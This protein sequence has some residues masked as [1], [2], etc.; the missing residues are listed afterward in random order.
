LYLDEG[1]LLAAVS[2]EESLQKLLVL[3]RP[4]THRQLRHLQRCLVDLAEDAADGIRHIAFLA[5]VQL[6]LALEAPEPRVHRLHY[7][8]E[9]V[10][11]SERGGRQGGIVHTRNALQ[12]L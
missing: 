7:L 2:F 12:H 3:L 11:V 10:C 6:N 4:F 5:H 1:F 9:G 8:H